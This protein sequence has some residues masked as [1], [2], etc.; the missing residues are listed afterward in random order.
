LTRQPLARET[1]IAL[2]AFALVKLLLPLVDTAPFGYFRDEL[3]LIVCGLRP[4]WGY[5]DHPPLAPLL[6]AA[7]WRLFGETLYGVR[8]FPAVFGAATVALTVL[9]ARRLGA[10]PFGQALAGLGLLLAPFYLVIGA[11]LSTDSFEVLFSTLLAWATLRLVQDGDPRAWLLF[12]AAAGLGLE[13]KHSILFFALG[14][15]AGLVVV[16][17][18]DLLKSRRVAAGAG[19]AVLLFLPNL[20]WQWRHGWPT[21]ELLNNI[22]LGD[23]NVVLGPLAYLGEQVFLL[24]PLNLPLWLLG[25]FWLLRAQDDRHLRAFGVA[26]LVTFAVIVALKGKA[27]YLGP[28]YPIL[29][30]GGAVAFERF[31]ATGLRRGLR[32][33]WVGL[34]LAFTALILPMGFPLLSPERTAAHLAW[35]GIAPKPTEHSHDGVLPQNL[36]D[37]LG[38]E[39]MVAGLARA[40]RSLPAAD[41]A[42]AGIFVQNFGQAGAVDVLGRGHGLPPALSGHQ[43]YFLWGPRGFTGEV[44]LVVDDG[45]GA[46]PELCASLEDLGPAGSHPYALPGE[47]RNR[48]YLCRGLRPPLDQLWPRVKVWM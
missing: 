26:W 22:R 1:W 37:R 30:A 45:P 3:Y 9:L 7:G 17:R 27:Y 10:G 29:F 13:A 8:F 33:L 41:R 2:A 18:W 25:L 46:L 12:G 36:A 16:R 38:W 19:L 14:L 5:V 4:D 42:A 32:A 24:G 44:L 31:T 34:S 11:K 15:V 35:I 48:I 23:K 47:R 21:F 39:E 28:A 20:L 40:Y 6:A 43:N